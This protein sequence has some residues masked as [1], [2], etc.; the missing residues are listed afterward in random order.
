MERIPKLKEDM[1][2][3]SMMRKDSAWLYDR[4]FC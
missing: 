3:I 1:F 2:I 4:L